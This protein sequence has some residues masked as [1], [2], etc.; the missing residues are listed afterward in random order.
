MHQS[1]YS[2][3]GVKGFQLMREPVLAALI[4]VLKIKYVCTLTNCSSYVD[5]RCELHNVISNIELGFMSLTDLE[6][7]QMMPPHKHVKIVKDV[8]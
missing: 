7:I 6:K 5:Y 1:C 3:E 2:Q 8:A 4:I